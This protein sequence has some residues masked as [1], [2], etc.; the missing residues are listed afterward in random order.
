MKTYLAV[1]AVLFALSLPAFGSRTPARSSQFNV[2][3]ATGPVPDRLKKAQRKSPPLTRQQKLA[4]ARAPYSHTFHPD[5]PVNN[6]APTSVGL[7][8]APMIYLGGEDD[9][10]DTGVLAD[11]NGDGK[12]DVAKLITNL[13]DT[14]WTTQISVLLSNG[15][16]TFKTAVVSNLLVNSD[17]PIFAADLNGDGK[18]D[19]LQAH[20]FG[21]PSTVDVYLSNGDGTFATATTF[22]LSAFSLSG[23]VLTDVNGDGKLDILMVDSE[24]HAK[25]SYALGN[26]DGTFQAPVVLAS[27]AGPV[28]NDLFFADFNGDGKMDFAGTSEGYQMTVYLSSGSTY[29]SYNLTASA[30]SSCNSIAADLNGD[31]KPEIISANCND[32]SITVYVNNGDGSFQSGVNYSVPGAGYVEPYGLAV[33]DF[34]RDGKN[35]VIV[36]LGYAGQIALFKGKG[37][38]TLTIPTIAFNTGGFPWETPLVADFNGDGFLDIMESDDTFTMAYLQGYGDGTFKTSRSYYPP[39]T[40]GD[41]YS[42]SIAT[43]DF[44]GDGFP[45]IVLGQSADSSSLPGIVVFLA[46]ADGSL[47]SGVTYGTSTSLDYVAVADFNGDGKLDIA[48]S[49]SSAGVVQIFL[50]KGDGTFTVGQTF[51][52][53]G[54]GGSEPQNVVVGDFNHDGKLDLAVANFATQN[55]GVLLGNGDGTFGAPTNYS[56]GT[57]VGSVTTGDL[58]G[59]GY[60]DLAVT[61]PDTDGDLVAVLLANSDNSGTFQAALPVDVGIGN[62]YSV[63][64]GDL[65]GDGKADLAVTLDYGAIF[66]GGAIA[67]ALGNGDGTF[68]PAVSYNST[69]I[70]GSLAYP[71]PEAMVMADFNGDGNLDL[72][73]NNNEYGTVGIMYG[74]GDGTFYDPIDFAAS[75]YSSAIVL[76]DMN[77]D[78]AVDVVVTAD[79][80]DGATVLLN[81]SGSK[82]QPGFAIGASQSS[83]TVVAGSA[84]TYNLTMTGQNGYSGSI[85]FSCSGL[86]AGATCTFS[87]ASVAMSGNASLATMLT[88]T[89][90]ASTSAALGMPQT[91]NSKPG[92]PMLLASL[93]SLGLFGLVLGGSS[94]KRRVQMVMTVLPVLLMAGMLIGC[95]GG[96]GGTSST[97]PPTSGTPAGT[98]TIPVQGTGS[99]NVSRTTNV[100]LV[101]Q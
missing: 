56:L 99:G 75:A 73:Y 67:V 5:G 77:A 100:Q 25:V 34:N 10:E 50:G 60:L 97:K 89:T 17:D 74:K 53:D 81:N 78:G 45:D 62:A 92:S 61:L 76:A 101:V 9:D 96:T 57:Y 91:P 95:A 52:T 7:V 33:A 18:A 23:G 16:G 4:L 87:P 70:G 63:A 43:G 58:N 86:P 20:P 26:G 72:I 19:L 69:T 85:T 38:A 48:A 32:D 41:S 88:I 24:N 30:Y 94:K 13:I 84:A 36:S 31:G 59:D 39:E 65:N 3:H 11:F 37:D 27:L 12:T 28:P 15:D 42:Y 51:S 35:D 8:T 83:Q 47:R 1:F 54:D 71:R 6:T 80:A 40:D 44:N 64:I 46:N 93:A 55:V 2:K 68:L 21:T 90:T 22:P 98:Y 79:Y 49:D 66:Q 14:T 29:A 82:T